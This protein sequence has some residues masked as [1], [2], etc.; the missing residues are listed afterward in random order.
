MKS[1][2]SRPLSLPAFTLL[3]EGAPVLP[4]LPRFSRAADQYRNLALQLEERHRGADGRGYVVAVTSCDESAGKTLTSLNIALTLAGTWD[5]KVLL[6]EGD[7]WRPALTDYLELDSARAGV[8]QILRSETTLREAVIPV[9]ER[10]PAAESTGVEVL[11]AGP[12]SVSEDLIAGSRG[13]PFL[14]EVRQHYRTIVIDCPPGEVASGRSLVSKA[15]SVVLV[16]RAG[17][18]RR[19]RI[20]ATLTALG[21]HK[22]LGFLL[23]AVK[24]ADAVGY[25]S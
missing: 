2:T 21:P 24:E 4:H 8:I 14:E 23:N 22:H 12:S 25:Y 17:R 13:E 20:E 16:V 6:V 15:D 7:L 10:N 9:R 1:F 19:S 18:T 5:R 3:R 11:P